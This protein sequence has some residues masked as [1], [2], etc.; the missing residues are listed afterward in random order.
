MAEARLQLT[1][2]ISWHFVLS[3]IEMFLPYT[4]P[5][6]KFKKRHSFQGI[7][8]LLKNCCKTLIR[9]RHFTELYQRIFAVN[10]KFTMLQC[11][12]HSFTA[13]FHLPLGQLYRAASIGSP[14]RVLQGNDTILCGPQTEGTKERSGEVLWRQILQYFAGKGTGEGEEKE[15]DMVIAHQVCGWQC[16]FIEMGTTGRRPGSMGEES[17]RHLCL[18]TEIYS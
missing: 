15:D 18:S 14:A 12:R 4:V 3:E 2:M 11:E 1:E 10:K 13:L 16:H 17:W 8:I 5:S 9:T 6:G 7:S